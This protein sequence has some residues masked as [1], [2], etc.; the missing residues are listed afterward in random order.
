MNGLKGNFDIYFGLDG[1]PHGLNF[2]ASQEHWLR[3][4][5]YQRRDLRIVESTM[6][7]ARTLGEALPVDMIASIR[8]K[9]S[10]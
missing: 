4:K 1:N 7:A 3:Q 10:T 5:A 2:R 9:A 8:E 6:S